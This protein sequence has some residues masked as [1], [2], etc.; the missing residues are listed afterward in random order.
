M[1]KIDE[2][3]IIHKIIKMSVKKLETKENW[4]NLQCHIQKRAVG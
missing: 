4:C 3:I 1:T 2:K